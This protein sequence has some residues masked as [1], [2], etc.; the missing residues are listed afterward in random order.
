MRASQNLQLRELSLFCLLEVFYHHTSVSFIKRSGKFILCR[1]YFSSIPIFLL[2][3]IKQDRK[4]SRSS[5]KYKKLSKVNLKVIFNSRIL[6]KMW[7]GDKV[8]WSSSEKFGK[9]KILW[10]VK[11]KLHKPKKYYSLLCIFYTNKKH[12]FLGKKIRKKLG[13][14][15]CK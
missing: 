6:A 7:I 3:P 11:V 1:R 13:K 5:R 15:N 2:G 9:W 10:L 12:F 8:T 4:I 14:E